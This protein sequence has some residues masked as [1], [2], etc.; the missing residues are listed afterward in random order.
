[1]LKSGKLAAGTKDELLENSVE[2][3]LMW[4]AF[5]KLEKINV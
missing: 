5:H 3:R 2:F 4:D 1:M